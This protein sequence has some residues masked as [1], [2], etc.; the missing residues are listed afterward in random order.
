MLQIC[1]GKK[2]VLLNYCS[3]DILY[4]NSSEERRKDD[5]VK[6]VPLLNSSVKFL[7]NSLLL[8]DAFF[9]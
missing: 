1:N 4:I 7:P 8:F 2:N 6:W 3:T 9:P 5:E